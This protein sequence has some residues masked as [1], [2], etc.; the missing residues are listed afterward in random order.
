MQQFHNLSP[1]LRVQVTG[2]LIG[3]YYLRVADNGAGNG[4]TLALTT[5]ELCRH[6]AHTVAQTYLLQYLFRQAAAFFGRHLSIK[7]GQFYII[8]HIQR[9]NQVERLEYEAQLHVTESSKFLV[10]HAVYLSA[11]YFDG[12]ACRRIEQ[13][14]NVQQRGLTATGRSHNTQEFSLIHFEVNIL[15]CYG[16]NL[17]RTINLV[18]AS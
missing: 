7:Q 6:V 5:G 4:N 11:C 12:T 10:L 15:Q 13:T 3:E 1:H 9:V 8:Q 2:R 18:D 14:H 17:V 16:F